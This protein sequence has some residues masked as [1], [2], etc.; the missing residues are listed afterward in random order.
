MER[1]TFLG[2]SAIAAGAASMVGTRAARAQQTEPV[3]QVAS[4]IS[5]NHGHA[6]D[7]TLTQ[8]IEL[9][10]VSSTDGLVS[11]SIQG[12]S[13]HN[14]DLSLSYLQLLTFLTNG[15]LTVQSSKISGHTHSVELTLVKERVGPARGGKEDTAARQSWPIVS[16][17]LPPARSSLLRTQLPQRKR[18]R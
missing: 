1:R 13:G 5:S 16:G 17:L 14:H 4:T 18:S 8:V 11:L 12:T 3:F 2:A 15:A 10:Q 7:L 9:L 6:V